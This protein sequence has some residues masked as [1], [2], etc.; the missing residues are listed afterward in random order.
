MAGRAPID[1]R[2]AVGVVLCDMWRAA[3][4]TTT[5]DEVGRVIILVAAH[6]AAGLS[7]VVDHVQ[8]GRA[9]GRAVGLGQPGI[10]DEPVAVL[11]H[12]VPHVSE[13]GP[14][15]DDGGRLP[16]FGTK[17]FMLAPASISVPSTE[18]CSLENSEHT[19]GRFSTV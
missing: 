6:G 4:F 10:D 12:Q 7:I 2:A 9:L 19:C 1:R 5:G 8:R 16:S 18:K 15:P 11:H 3:A 17:L 13:L 14:F